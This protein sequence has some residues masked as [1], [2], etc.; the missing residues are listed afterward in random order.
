MP[1]LAGM[2]Q[3]IVIDE[4]LKQV[5]INLSAVCTNLHFNEIQ[6]NQLNS[7]KKILEKLKIDLDKLVE[8]FAENSSLFSRAAMFWGK[9]S[10]WQ[11]LSL[12]AIIFVPLFIATLV[13][14]LM[15]LLIVSLSVLFIFTI[16]GFFLNNHYKHCEKNKKNL[17]Q[18]FASFATI[19]SEVIIALSKLHDQLWLTLAKVHQELKVLSE[20]L[21]KLDDKMSIM[22]DE[23]I[24]LSQANAELHIIQ[25]QLE[26]L[27]AELS[28]KIQEQTNFI[29]QSNLNFKQIMLDAEAR[30][31]E[32]SLQIIQLNET[33]ESL[34][35]ELKKAKQIGDILKNA[36]QV[37]SRAIT[38]DNEQRNYFQHRLQKI[39]NNE[40]LTLENFAQSLVKVEEDLSKIS[41]HFDLLNH[42]HSSLLD[43][44]E[45]QIERLEHFVNNRL[46]VSSALNDIGIFSN[47]KSEN[48]NGDK[49][50]FCPIPSS[51]SN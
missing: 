13:S 12:G 49:N 29:D 23:L 21:I 20:Q 3:D 48:L 33:N 32:L 15:P 44:Q 18:G 37:V 17:K 8:T 38:T 27:V 34:I 11:R 43:Q 42:G 1:I 26:S 31:S 36:L 40:E 25:N 35:L 10:W 46:N 30:Q 39:L 28:L 22:G 41:M 4:K 19:L 5:N 2:Q 45:I 14:H 6:L 7:N 50:T 24:N 16:S 9:L 51:A 47:S